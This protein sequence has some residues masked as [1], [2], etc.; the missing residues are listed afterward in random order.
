MNT[1]PAYRQQYEERQRQMAEQH[2]AAEKKSD[3]AIKE[4]EASMKEE[5]KQ[6]SPMPPS[7]S[8]APSQSDLG[9]TPQPPS[10]SRDSPS[11]PSSKSL[12]S[13]KGEDP[14]SQQAEG[15]KMKLTEGGH[16][17][18]ED[19]KQAL[20]SRGQAGMEQAMWYRQVNTNLV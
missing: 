7:L 8:K 20:E 12:G 19:S 2:R 13:I 14:K 11:E 17:G 10:K 3:V 6:K 18:K 9:K 16:H 15:L 4:R 1:N 5:W